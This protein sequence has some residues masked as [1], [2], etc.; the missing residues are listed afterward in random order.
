M[1]CAV[2][3]WAFIGDTED[4]WSELVRTVKQ[5]AVLTTWW[6]LVQAFWK[7]FGPDP[8]KDDKSFHRT[9]RS[10]KISEKLVDMEKIAEST[11]VDRLE[12]AFSTAEQK[13]HVA[14][15]LQVKG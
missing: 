4:V 12:N 3:P 14:R 5:K 10:A 6:N 2:N 1:I 11:S 9:R 7:K 15:L 8:I 13:F